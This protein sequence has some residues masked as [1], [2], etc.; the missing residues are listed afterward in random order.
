MPCIV[1]RQKDYAQ[2]IKERIIAT[3][4]NAE[5]KSKTLRRSGTSCDTHLQRRVGRAMKSRPS[6]VGGHIIDIVSE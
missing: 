1:F 3:L 6:A 4:A 5:K 2:G